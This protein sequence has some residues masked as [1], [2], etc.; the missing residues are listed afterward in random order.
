MPVQLRGPALGWL[1]PVL[2]CAQQQQPPA[3]KP[4]EA[5]PKLTLRDLSGALESLTQRVSPAVVQVFVSGYGL[6][7]DE[8][9]PNVG[10]IARQRGSGSGVIVDATGYIVTNAH[11]V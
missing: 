6:V 11:V 3:P 4:T 10:F 1:L 5:R 7:Q 2:L 9:S 8:D